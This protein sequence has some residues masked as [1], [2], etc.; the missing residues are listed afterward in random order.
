MKHPEKYALV[1]QGVSAETFRN[2]SQRN[3]GNPARLFRILPGTF[4]FS[5]ILMVDLNVIFIEC[6][7][8]YCEGFDQSVSQ[9]GM[10]NFE[11]PNSSLTLLWL[12]ELE[13]RFGFKAVF[14]L[15]LIDWTTR[16][17]YVY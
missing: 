1:L 17:F 10:K 3:P 2:T 12:F 6:L 13:E 5:N 9:T 16:L 14:R 15:S 8:S 11:R 7:R 4:T